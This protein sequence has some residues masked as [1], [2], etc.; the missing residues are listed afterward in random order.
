MKQ[1]TIDDIRPNDYLKLQKYLIKNCGEPDLGGIY[2]IPLPHDLLTSI[3]A[4]HKTC[5]PLFFALDLSKQKLSAE[6]LV[7][8][9]KK[10][11]CDC[12]GYATKAQRNWLMD[13]VDI[14]LE[15]LK[16]SI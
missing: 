13:Y 15:N 7:R 14:M 4:E 6:F 1:Y 3:Q 11:R 9:K 5:Q 12:M 2:W 10:I 8:T 16:I